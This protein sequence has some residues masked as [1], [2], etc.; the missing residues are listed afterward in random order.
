MEIVLFSTYL[1]TNVNIHLNKKDLVNMQQTCKSIYNSLSYQI[2][3]VR[4]LETKMQFKQQLI[5]HVLDAQKRNTAKN[6][7]K[8]YT[9]CIK[10]QYQACL[11][12]RNKP[13]IF[14]ELIFRLERMEGKKKYNQAVV[15]YFLNMLPKI[16]C[17]I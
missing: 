10:Y 6:L 8:I 7:F 2:C 12:F 4:E 5:N 11:F 13:E 17:N 16:Y 15:K 9:H 3:I 1:I 14:S